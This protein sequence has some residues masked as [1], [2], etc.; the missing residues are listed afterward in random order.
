MNYSD[1]EAGQRFSTP[2]GEP[3]NV[4]RHSS[5][6]VGVICPCAWCSPSSSGAVLGGDPAFLFGGGK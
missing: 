3:M 6:L 5:F 2:P 1:Q 4:A